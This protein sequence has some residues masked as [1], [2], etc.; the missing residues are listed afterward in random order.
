MRSIKVFLGLGAVA[1]LMTVAAAPAS[2]TWDLCT[3]VK[4]PNGSFE[5]SICSKA[6]PKGAWEWREV[7]S[8]DPVKLT[9]ATG[10]KLRLEDMAAET[11]IECTGE[12]EGTV[13]TGNSDSIKSITAKACTFV[14]HGKCEESD[15]VTASAV[16]TPWTTELTLMGGQTWDTIKSSGAGTPGWTVECTVLGIFKIADTCE[17]TAQTKMENQSNGTVKASF[18]GAASGKAKCS[19]GGA[20]QG[21]VEGA[22]IITATS[23]HGL[24]FLAP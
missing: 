15:P 1:L 5:N 23:G 17:G 22:T 20:E 14:K 10:Q 11:T 7:T 2:A 3:E 13:G 12:G 24:K 18:E 8:S 16:H 4:E 21:L 9:N 19:V 6:K